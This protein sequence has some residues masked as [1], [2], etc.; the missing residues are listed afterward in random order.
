MVDLTLFMVYQDLSLENVSNRAE[1]LAFPERMVQYPR[2]KISVPSRGFPK[3]L[4]SKLLKYHNL[5]PVEGH[6]RAQ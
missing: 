1:E 5:D 3:P 4:Q 2:G 6:P